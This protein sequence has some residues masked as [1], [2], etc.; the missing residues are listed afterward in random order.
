MAVASKIAESESDTSGVLK[1]YELVFES[2]YSP[3]HDLCTTFY[4]NYGDIYH[5][6]MITTIFI[7]GYLLLEEDYGQFDVMAHLAEIYDEKGQIDRANTVEQRLELLTNGGSI[8]TGDSLLN[9]KN[10]D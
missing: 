7:P 4:K 9:C 3:T 1:A 2:I 6:E 5:K 10:Q 8:E